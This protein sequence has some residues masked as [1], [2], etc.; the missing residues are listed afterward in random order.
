VGVGR[1]N[2]FRLDIKIS[3]IGNVG[4]KNGGLENG[5][6]GEGRGMGAA[7][8]CWCLCIFLL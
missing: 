5:W 2:E 8:F 1:G 4:T 6:V 3:V 7:G